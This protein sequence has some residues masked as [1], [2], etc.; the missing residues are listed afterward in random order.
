MRILDRYIGREVFSHALLGLAV[1][2][3]VFFVPKLV[4]LMSLVVRHTGSIADIALLMTCTLLQVLPYTLPMAALI[5]VLIGLGR[6]S[7]DSEIVALNA[8]GIGLRRLLLPI[9]MLALGIGLF[10]LALTFWTGPASLRA[11]HDLEFRLGSAQASY[12]IQPRVFDERFPH[13]VLYVQ[14]V[15]STALRWRGVF[16][17]ESNASA[18]SHVTLSEEA[19]VVADQ[20]QGKLDL[21]LANGSIHEYDPNDP[22]HYGFTQFGTHDEPVD[23]AQASQPESVELSDAERSVSQLLAEHGPDWR[24]AR[25]EFHRRIA[26]P[27]ACLIFALLG[28]P[29]GVR[30]RRGGRASGFVLTLLLLCG[31]Y[32][33]FVTGAHMAQQGRLP[34]SLGIWAANLVTLAIALALLWRIE[35]VHSGSRI[36]RWMAPYAAAQRLARMVGRITAVRTSSSSLERVPIARR[37]IGFPLLID[38]YVLRTFLYFFLLMLAGFIVLFDSFTIFDLLE[39]ISKHHIPVMVVVNYLR[40]LVPS[41]IYQLVPLA[42]LVATLVTLGV[43]AKNNEIT[44]FK[45]AGIS[46]YRLALPL[47]VAGVL[48]AGALFLLDDT[49]LPYANQKQ[50]ALR[51]QIKGRP[52]QTYY[53]PT[54]QWIFGEHEK[55]YNYELFD[56]DKNFFGGLNVFE[57]DPATFQLRRR[58]LA[59]RAQW[60][61]QLNTWVLETGW[62]RDFANG[63]LTR[64]LPFQVTSLEELSEPPSYFKREV[65]QSSQM[66]WHQLEQYIGDLQHAGF[67]TTRLSVQW[68]KKFA[69]PLIALFLIFLAVPFAFLVGTRG[70][71]GGLAVA[72]GIGIAYWAAAALFEAMGSIGQLPPVL[73][74]WAPDAIFGFLGLYFF[75][76]MPT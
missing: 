63:K 11:L 65:R 15:D 72:V 45:A 24:N 44:A 66:N 61:P 38:L 23:L 59:T 6:L 10:T 28:V 73:A 34:P 62:V 30:P 19:I 43:L 67:D 42:A 3:F 4:S 13:L 22:G 54:H 75:L 58:I 32:L 36:A 37:L 53:Q 17:A 27:A 5:G 56:A 60:E 33:V 9:G 35:H 68:H 12:E 74:A 71:V 40:Y 47:F 18:A 51:A 14:D 46:L 31:Y 41:M 50:D 49:Y 29:V 26:F 64:Y 52:T 2:T 70:A 57:L 20:G 55:I 1:F 48:M 16:L 69:F 39:D 7:A 76:K 21:H 25:V 8:A